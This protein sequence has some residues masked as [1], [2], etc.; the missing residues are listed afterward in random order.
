MAKETP[1]T[2]RVMPVSRGYSLVRLRASTSGAAA[3]VCEGCIS[4][5]G[6]TLQRA[7][8]AAACAAVF[9]VCC[10]PPRRGAFSRWAIFSLN[11][12]SGGRTACPGTTDP[13]V[14]RADREETDSAC[15]CTL[16][17][18]ETGFD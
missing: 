8:N 15:R 18:Q 16:C 14:Y 4:E 13:R 9:R 17:S 1:S 12:C 3:E 2:T 7:A 10:W 5:D 6:S 11:G